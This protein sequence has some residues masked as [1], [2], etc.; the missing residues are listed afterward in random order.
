MNFL[1]NNKK[2][3]FIYLTVVFV[4]GVIYIALSDGFY[5]IDEGAQYLTNRNV[6]VNPELSLSPWARFGRAW[7]YAPAAFF[8]HKATKIMAYAIFVLCLAVTYKAAR[9]L[10][11]KYAEY[12]ILF[13]GFQPVF[14]DLSYSVMAEMP[15]AFLLILSFWLFLEKRYAQSMLSASLILI[16]RYELILYVMIL[17]FFFIKEKK[18]KESLI[19]ITGP[20]IW[21]G[22]SAILTGDVFWL[23][24][25]FQEF[26]KLAKHK[27]GTELYH[28]FI[29]TPVIF[30]FL[31]SFFAIAGSFNKKLFEKRN[32]I[33]LLSTIGWTYFIN[34]ITSVKYFSFSGSV[35]DWRYLT[36]VAP[37]FGIFAVAG[38][39]WF[40]EK[41]GILTV[42]FGAFL[43]ALIVLT[44][45]FIIA[46][47][48]NYNDYEKTV[49]I[50]FD[51]AKQKNP[52]FKILTNDFAL[53]VT[54]ELPFKNSEKIDRLD[55]ITLNTLER[56]YILWEPYNCEGKVNNSGFSLNALR[57]GPQYRF[58]DSVLYDKKF[59]MYLIEKTK[60]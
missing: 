20:L 59:W 8:G 24:Q 41:T 44:N 4:T 1:E 9:K 54:L 13:T 57:Q 56:G 12:V 50:L 26:S 16:F 27:E 10:N 45:C 51:K 11:L 37:F 36:P 5:F 49:F 35:G 3:F 15:A 25:A 38:F 60:I 39:G 22:W 14:F 17:I 47:P 43:I 28:Y 31:I 33:I 48:H 42:K 2:L 52:D 46:K 30:G 53:F 19:A 29:L 21:W 18:Y 58:C 55:E 7:L 23:K 40:S 34:I 32:Y 6:W